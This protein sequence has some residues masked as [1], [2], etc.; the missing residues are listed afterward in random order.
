[1][2]WWL[3]VYLCITG[4]LILLRSGVA[5]TQWRRE[6]KA[7]TEQI[8][9]NAEYAQKRAEDAEAEAARVAK[10]SPEELKAERKAKRV[11]MLAD[12]ERM[13]DNGFQYAG[14]GYSFASE[15]NN[16]QSFKRIGEDDELTQEEIDDGWEIIEAGLNRYKGLPYEHL[17]EYKLLP[18]GKKELV[19]RIPLRKAK[20]PSAA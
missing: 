13:I 20:P 1:M 14:A 12:H 10:L 9:R 8:K 4:F 17:E 3:V 19:R 18:N 2:P 5:F 7:K 16:M 6:K 11:K 15:L